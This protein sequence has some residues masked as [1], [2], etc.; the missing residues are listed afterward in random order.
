M[1]DYTERM[2]KMNEEQK[3]EHNAKKKVAA[4]AYKARKADAKAKI[5]EFLASKESKSLTPE[6]RE[7]IE[8]MTGTGARVQRAGV[9]NELKELLM[10]GPVSAID[11]FTKFEYGRP[12]METKIRNF[13]KADPSER[14]WVAFEKGNYIVKAVGENAPEDWTGY[15]P[16]VKSETEEL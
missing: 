9:T 4:D 8:Y 1:S 12:A 6:V 15:V 3:A 2:S 7:A 5:K 10:T 14:I 11:I 16:A 13:I